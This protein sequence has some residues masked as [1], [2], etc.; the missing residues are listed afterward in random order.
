MTEKIKLS[1]KDYNF[2]FFALTQ[3]Y[4]D[5]WFLVEYGLV[6]FR[7]FGFYTNINDHFSVL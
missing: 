6:N 1:L 3:R 2:D 5:K 4:P 7:K